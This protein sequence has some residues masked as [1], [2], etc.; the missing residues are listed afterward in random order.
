MKVTYVMML[1]LLAFAG[2]GA[3]GFEKLGKDHWDAEFVYL[4]TGEISD[5]R[6]FQGEYIHI[7]FWDFKHRNDIAMLDSVYC[8]LVR[9][10]FFLV[11][12]IRTRDVK[13]VKAFVDRYDFV[14]PVFVDV[15]GELTR[16]FGV[17]KVPCDFVIAPD[18]SVVLKHQGEVDWPSI[19][20]RFK[21][22][23]KRKEQ[24]KRQRNATTNPI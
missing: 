1:L 19:A 16:Q 10:D 17:K 23:P 18:G 3:K 21:I 24:K 11:P 6:A 13:R 8:S 4:E 12:I 5:L 14:M 22:F 7:H 20:L 9:D 2:A 15:T